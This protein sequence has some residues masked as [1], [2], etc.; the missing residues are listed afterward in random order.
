MS[1]HHIL[2]AIERLALLV[3]LD[4]AR[5]RRKIRYR[6]NEKRFHSLICLIC[7]T[8]KAAKLANPELDALRALAMQHAYAMPSSTENGA[9]YMLDTA[10]VE[11]ARRFLADE[12]VPYKRPLPRSVKPA[13][14]IGR[15]CGA[16]N[17]ADGEIPALFTAP[18]S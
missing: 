6:N 15:I 1:E 2:A 11:A 5:H 13:P 16:A 9:G 10:L 17:V 3:G 12:R 4:D 8:E 14:W 18:A 7:G